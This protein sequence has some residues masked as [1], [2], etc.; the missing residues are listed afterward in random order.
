MNITWYGHSC[1][2][3]QTK[4]ERG[5]E[6]INLFTDPFDK[7]IGLR[8]PQGNADIVTISHQHFDHNQVQSLKNNPF[9]IDAPGEYSLK[10][11]TIRGIEAFHD[12][13][14]GV[15]KGRNTI[16]TIESEDLRLCHLGDLGH[17]LEDKQIDAIGAV[18]ILMIPV[19]GKNTL[20]STLAEKVVSQLEPKIIL[21]MHY[22]L[23]N[24]SFPLDSVEKFCNDL[25]N[26][27]EKNIPRLVI[28]KKD[29]EEISGK[30][31]LLEV[32]N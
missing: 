28:K 31:I 11:I 2:R 1:F 8:P 17:L 29:L 9:I 12:Q 14:R 15:K 21:P 20:D 18:D 27:T 22:A 24:L 23:P 19:G 26:E 30:I 6:E 13:E 32:A 16:F 25:G 3:I 4:K 5:G 10:G 7:S